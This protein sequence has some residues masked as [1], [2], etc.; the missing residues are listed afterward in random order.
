MQ[1]NL[2]RIIAAVLLVATIA[3]SFALLPV[4]QY[5]T[6]L[7]Q[8]AQ[9]NKALGAVLVAVI[10]VP[11]CLLFIPGT[12]ITLGAG[13]AFGVLWGTVAVS[14]GSVAGATAAFLAGR[15][16]LRG[17]IEDR[18]ANNA[19]FAAIDRA[20]GV[21]GFKIVLLT[22]LSPVFPFNLLNYAYGLT[23]VR[24]RDYVLASWIGMLPATIMFVYFGS[25][26]KDIANLAAGAGE[27]SRGQTALNLVGLLA[28]IAVTVFV[29]RVARRALDEAVSGDESVE[30]EE[31]STDN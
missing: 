28:T 13:F 4:K 24:L 16:L 10:Y 5:L 18:V 2:T 25:A 31:E 8:W 11:A 14:I 12:L 19:K 20:V 21:E 3:A 26:V 15:G 1:A 22:R 9:A 30:A 23:K 17:M 29:T 6:E 7:L 27:G